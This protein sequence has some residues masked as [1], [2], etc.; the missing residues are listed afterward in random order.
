MKEKRKIKDEL[1]DL[2]DVVDCPVCN[3]TTLQHITDVCPICGWEHDP[4]QSYNFEES[5]YANQLSVN[6]SREYFKLKRIQNPKYTWKAN[7]REVGNPTKD[8]LEKLRAEVES[9]K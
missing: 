7:A 5:Q 6:E 3:E 2:L 8:D 1:I 9:K 4:V